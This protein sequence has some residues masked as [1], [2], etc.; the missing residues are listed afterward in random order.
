MAKW[1]TR[2]S[3]LVAALAAVI[4]IASAA[5]AYA[6]FTGGGTGTTHGDA[7]G[8][9]SSLSVTFGTPTGTMYPG[10]GFSVIPYTVTNGGSGTQQLSSVTAAVNADG[11]GNITVSGTAVT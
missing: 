6:Y 9:S 3:T 10:A 4:A 5:G 7:V 1:I 8:E 11:S 2:K